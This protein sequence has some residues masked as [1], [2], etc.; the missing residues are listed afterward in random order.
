[1]DR[2]LSEA[3]K[4]VLMSSLT[5]WRH[6][7]R[8]RWAILIYYWA[9]MAQRQTNSTRMIRDITAASRLETP[10]RRATGRQNILRSPATRFIQEARVSCSRCIHPTSSL[11]AG[12]LCQPPALQNWAACQ[13][14]ALVENN[15]LG[16]LQNILPYHELAKKFGIELRHPLWDHRILEFVLQLPAEQ[17]YQPALK[18]SS[19]VTPCGVLPARLL[20]EE[21]YIQ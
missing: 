17:T 11:R 9:A 2:Y 13:G 5:A 21:K 12:D 19:C 16:N 8:G 3:Q 18:K 4:Q 15:T 14:A 6:V 20:S 7:F 10:L 1:M